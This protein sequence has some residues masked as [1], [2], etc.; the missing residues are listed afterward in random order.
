MA[1]HLHRLTA[2]AI[3]NLKT[4]GLHSDGGGLYVRVTGN[5]TKSWIFRYT[6]AGCT[7]DMGLGPY[8]TVT[9]GRARELAIECRRQ[10][11]DG[12][13]PIK[14]RAG[15]RAAASLEGLRATTFKA[16]AEQLVSSHEIG[17]RNTKHRLEW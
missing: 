8:P 10:R 13:D 2:T 16:C 5:G 1:R 17:W 3:T 9:L 14:A 11:Q 15:E 4:K 6:S 12:R 7:R